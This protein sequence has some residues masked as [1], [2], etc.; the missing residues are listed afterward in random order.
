VKFT[1]SPV[2]SAIL[3]FV[4]AAAPAF[5]QQGGVVTSGNA[6][7]SNPTPTVTQINQ[8]TE[9]AIIQWQDFSIQQGNTAVFNQPSATSIALN[10]VTG[11]APS[12]ILGSL[13]ANGQVW[14]LNPNGILFGANATINVGALVASTLSLSDHDFLSGQYKFLQDPS[15]PSSYVVNQGS[16]TAT[17]FAA[18]IAPLVENSGSITSEGGQVYLL[19]TGE[20]VLDIAGTGLIG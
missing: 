1:P 14:I 20:A 13:Q 17:S 3:A 16:V 2:I 11:N 19:G 18:L 6:T 9:K 15:K 5:A 10:R 4:A 8:T 12:S 7:I